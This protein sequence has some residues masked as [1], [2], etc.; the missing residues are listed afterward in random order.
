VYV[1]F[2]T[3][4]SLHEVGDAGKSEEGDEPHAFTVVPD[5]YGVLVTE[6]PKISAPGSV[7]P[8]HDTATV[9]PVG[10]AV[11]SVGADSEPTLAAPVPEPEE[12]KYA[13]APPTIAKTPTA[14]R[15][16]RRP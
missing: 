4:V 14:T 12:V 5:G 16:A 2:G 10:V 1:P 8:V 9:E 13:Q 6:Y 15:I 3:E 11:T 7:T